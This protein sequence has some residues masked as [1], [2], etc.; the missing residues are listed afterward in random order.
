[1]RNLGTNLLICFIII[2]LILPIG[3][4]ALYGMKKSEQSM[5]G[6]STQTGPIDV[7]LS[8][9][10]SKI[11][12]NIG[13]T[14]VITA[15]TAV[16]SE[17][18]IIQWDSGDKNVATVVR[19][20]D[21]QKTGIITAIGEGTT[22]ITANVIDKN[23]FKIIASA[24]CEITVID[25]SISF[26]QSEVIISLDEGNTATITAKAP[27]DG[28]IT[29]SSEDESIASVVGG[30]ITAHKP[31]Q[32]YIVAKSG[33]V[34]GKILVKIYNSVFKLEEVKIVAAGESASVQ[35]SGTISEGAVWTSSDERIVSVDQ[36][37][38][39]TG[40]KLGM[41]TI[42][43]KSAVDDL[44]SSCVVVVKSGADEAVQLESG[45]KAAAAANPGSWYFL[46]ESDN[47]TIGDIPTLD[48]GVI[49]AH[50][51]HVGDANGALSGANFFYLRYQP[52]EAGDVIYK[53]SLYLYSDSEVVL[54]INGKDVVYP[55]GYNRYEIEYLSSAPKNSNPYQIKFRC[56]GKFYIIPVFE[57]I[58]R[59]EKMTLSTTFEKLNTIDNTSLTLTATVPNVTDPT[60]DWSSSNEAVATVNN[61]V[62]TAVSEGSAMITA[63]FGNLSATCLITVEGETPITGDVLPNGN[64]SA[65]LGSPGEWFYLNDGKS[66]LNYKPL[67]DDE[68]NIHLSVDSVDDANKKYVYLR[69]QPETIGTY[70][71]VVTIDFAG[72]D[73]SVVEISGGNKSAEAKVLVN[74]TNTFEIEFTADSQNP[75]QMKFKASG[76]FVVNVTFSEV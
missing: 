30:V 19:D 46:C 29:W 43:V 13:A 53:H 54:Q 58:G 37:G 20:G 52:D 56:T 26:S 12:C 69:Y 65:S 10:E 73:N 23:Q 1:M 72:V 24:S 55:A 61:G 31:G 8:L 74:G 4:G 22:T 60:V 21:S 27:D 34:E 59:I 62:V 67:M 39:I 64:K 75:F 38:V 32:V 76:N 36:N 68:G 3:V 66:V 25:S 42:K 71:V 63:R 11:E 15:L 48:N 16:E 57:E 6:N 44:E 33:S 5:V 35:F 50:I 17:T 45:K 18:Y 51:T 14:K 70:K 7:G 47:V 41:A 40:V 28:E 2:A 49:S 9:S